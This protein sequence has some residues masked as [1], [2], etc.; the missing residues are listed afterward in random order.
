MS[1]STKPSR[2]AG[3]VLLLIMEV[4]G[5]TLDPRFQCTNACEAGDHQ[6]NTTAQ[7][8]VKGARAFHP[9]FLEENVPP[10]P[11]PTHI[12]TQT[13]THVYHIHRENDDDFDDDFSSSSVSFFIFFSLWR[14]EEDDDEDEGELDDDG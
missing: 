13:H 2:S 7:Q 6:N 11:T 10:T 1:K 8:G 12:H 14:K 5:S 9:S 3:F 4:E